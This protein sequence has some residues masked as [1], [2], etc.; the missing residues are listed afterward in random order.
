MFQIFL[1]RFNN[2]KKSPCMCLIVFAYKVHPEY[3]LILAGNRD[4]FHDRPSQSLFKWDTDPAIVAGKDIKGGGTWLGVSENGRIA[5]L[6]N[7]RD[8][9]RIKENVPSRGEII[10]EF[11]LSK[12]DL[13]PSLNQLEKK[14]GIYNCFNLIAGSADQL[15]YLSNHGHSLKAV[16][17]GVHVISN[18]ALNT[19]WPKAKWAFDRFRSILANGSLESE[20]IFKMLKSSDRYPIEMLPETGLSKEME[21]AVS[22]VFILT[23]HYGTRSSSMITIDKQYQ[24]EF[25]EKVY[26]PGTKKVES[27][28][29]ISMKLNPKFAQS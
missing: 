14:S 2:N 12:D 24:F 29:S 16:E 7:Y 3:P 18:A 9:Q 19:P 8:L 17:P 23:D 1:L 20:S 4:E 27:Q 6:T 26:R 15:F 25:S 10:P 13:Q 11:L 21:V 22:S 5:A 28:N